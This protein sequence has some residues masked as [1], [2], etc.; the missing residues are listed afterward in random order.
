[1]ILMSPC[2]PWVAPRRCNGAIY[3][4]K[5]WTALTS[6]RLEFLTSFQNWELGNIIIYQVNLPRWSFYFPL[7]DGAASFTINETYKVSSWPTYIHMFNEL[8]LIWRVQYSLGSTMALTKCIL[9]E[10]FPWS[11]LQMA[12]LADGPSAFPAWWVAKVPPEYSKYTIPL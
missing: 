6:K 11:C 10:Y 4:E 9:T 7:P 12:E 8:N 5:L 2:G 3:W 1:M